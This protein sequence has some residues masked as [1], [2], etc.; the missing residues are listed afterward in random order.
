MQKDCSEDVPA[1]VPEQLPMT[2][3]IK[4]GRLSFSFPDQFKSDMPKFLKCLNPRM[5]AKLPGQ[6]F[7]KDGGPVEIK[8]LTVESEKSFTVTVVLKGPFVF[9]GGKI[10]ISN[11]EL[12]VKK[13]EGEDLQFTGVT[14]IAVGS[15]AVGLT[16]E[17]QSDSYSLTATVDSFRLSQL[18]DVIGENS[19]TDFIGLLGNMSNFGVKDFKLAK[20][21]GAGNEHKLLRLLLYF[22]N[23]YPL[24]SLMTDLC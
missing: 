10:K 21:F 24:K 11:L 6:L 4:T 8:E 7:P 15:L 20:D 3:R 9:M 5:K 23:S 22:F 14:T 18:K 19:L 13:E 12:T 17:K 1:D 16:L 2:V